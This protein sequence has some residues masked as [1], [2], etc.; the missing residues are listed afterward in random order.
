MSLFLKFKNILRK[1]GLF[2]TRKKKSYVSSSR[3][4]WDK[5]YL[6][7]RTSG[8]GSY[9]RLAE[10]KAEVINEFVKSH[11]IESVLELGCGDG[12]QLL[13]ARYA[14]YIGYDVSETAIQ[15][16]RKLFKND[17]SKQFYLM[18]YNAGKQA[19]AELAMSLDVIYH[20]IE[21]EVFDD[22]MNRLFNSAER[23]V[24]IYSS[25]YDG[26]LARHVRSRKFTV[27]IDQ[28]VSDRWKLKDYI[29]NP[30]PFDEADPENTSISD[31]Y[32]YET[33]NPDQN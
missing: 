18:D 8:A 13:L 33:I 7:K 12:N 19:T 11:N 29:R 6:Q 15:M 28:H 25:N 9:G 1:T 24:I 10:Y 23:F 26:Y 31:F 17:N 20:L 30:F 21:D 3:D 32:I 27:W 2:G 4:Y 5:R 22:Y 14:H 16:C